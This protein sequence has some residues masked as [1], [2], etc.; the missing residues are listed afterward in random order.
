MI[1]FIEDAGMMGATRLFQRTNRRSAAMLAAFV[2]AGSATMAPTAALAQQAGLYSFHTAAASGCPA[3]DWHVVVGSD[4][5]LSGMVG[6]AGTHTASLGGTIGANGKF[7]ALAT[8]GATGKT[9]AVQGSVSGSYLQISV[10]GT[11][12]PCD[13]VSL[14]VP[15]AGGGMS[16][17]GG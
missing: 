7:N 1:I 14:N 13:N 5:K 15:R 3:L 16:G 8:E 4:R 6:W 12:S 17:G 9:A 2:I 10:S 11:G